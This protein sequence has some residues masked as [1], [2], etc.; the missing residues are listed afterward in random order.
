VVWLG[1]Q[2]RYQ[3]PSVA[4]GLLCAATILRATKPDPKIADAS[5]LW[6]E[7]MRLVLTESKFVL[8][9]AT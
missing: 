6:Q 9:V 8:D 5:I 1:F 3:I 4:L 2:T 7:K